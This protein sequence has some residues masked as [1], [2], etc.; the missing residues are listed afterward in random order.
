MK[1]IAVALSIIGFAVS[2]TAAQTHRQWETVYRP[3]PQVQYSQ[4]SYVGATG[5]YNGR[6]EERSAN[7]KTKKAKKAKKKTAP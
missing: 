6:F 2:P 5:E 3:S 7:F 4:P 1:K